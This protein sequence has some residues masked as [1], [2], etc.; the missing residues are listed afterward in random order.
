MDI[1]PLKNND[2]LVSSMQ[3]DEKKQQLKCKSTS[4]EN[5]SVVIK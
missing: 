5:F 3:N 2:F 1:K 4:P